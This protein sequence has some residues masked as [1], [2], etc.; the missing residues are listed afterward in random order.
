MLK[1]DIRTARQ[2]ETPAPVMLHGTQSVPKFNRTT[3]DDVEILLALYRIETKKVDL[4][5]TMNIPV[6]TSEPGAVSAEGFLA[7]KRD[8]DVAALSLNIVDYGLFA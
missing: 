7:A 8:F 5:L 4:V 6:K 3:S 1:V 2:G